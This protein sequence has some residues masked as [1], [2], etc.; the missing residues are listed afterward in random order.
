MGPNPKYIFQG[1]LLLFGVLIFSAVVVF[2]K[3]RS[4]WSFKDVLAGD[5]RISAFSLGAAAILFVVGLVI[6]VLLKNRG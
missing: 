3:V 2:L 5:R 1:L 4:G 6:F